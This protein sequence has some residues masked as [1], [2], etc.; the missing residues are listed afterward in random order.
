[1]AT[2]ND[3]ISGKDDKEKVVISANLEVGQ[4]RQLIKLESDSGIGFQTLLRVAVKS[5]IPKVKEL[6]P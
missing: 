2:I 5:G 6:Y 3:T 4:I 1:M